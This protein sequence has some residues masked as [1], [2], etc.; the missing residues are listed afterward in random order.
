M[1]ALLIHVAADTTGKKTV[2]ICGPIFDNSHFE[3]IPIP[4]R[5][6]TKNTNEIRTYES[7]KSKNQDFSKYISELVP[8]DIKNY[9][10]HYDPDFDHFTFA[11]PL[12][13]GRGSMLRKLLP[14]DLIFFVASLVPF[15]KEI[16]KNPDRRIICKYQ[17]GKMAKCIIGYFEIVKILSL[18]KTKNDLIEIGNEKNISKYMPQ[19]KHNAHNKR[20]MDRFTMV[21]GKKDRKSG[22]LSKA[23]PLTYPG[24]PFKPNNFAK[25]IFGNLSYPRGVKK[26]KDESKIKLLLKKVK[27]NI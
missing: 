25:Q 27:S 11:H 13:S 9:V 15:K 1:K 7:L 6:N 10:V 3:F 14:G 2:G 23:V 22:L 4:E 24:A 18:E 26:L 12:D 17:K 19:I 20:I 21:I 16:Y 8:S 5:K